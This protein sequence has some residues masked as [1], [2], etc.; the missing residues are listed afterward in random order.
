M[1]P[2]ILVGYLSS[3]P[4]AE[5]PANESMIVYCAVQLGNGYGY[6]MFGWALLTG[7]LLLYKAQMGILELLARNLTDAVVAIRPRFYVGLG[8]DPRSLYYPFLLLLMVVVGVLMHLSPPLD[9]IISSGNLTNLA[10]L[11]FPGAVLYL[12]RQLPRPARIGL[13]SHVVLI[14]NIVFFGFFF[15]NFVV[16]R[17]TGTPLLRF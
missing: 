1:A 7:F 11:I 14:A 16:L 3:Q 4:G 13:W 15:V 6:V 5:P 2:C 9:V 10:A 17:M 8:G 12:N